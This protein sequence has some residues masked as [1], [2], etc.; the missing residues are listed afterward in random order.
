VRWPAL[1]VQAQCLDEA[2]G[3]SGLVSQ[4]GEQTGAG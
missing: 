3:Q 1:P 2:A 4:I